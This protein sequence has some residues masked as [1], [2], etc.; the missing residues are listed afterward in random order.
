MKP[1]DDPPKAPDQQI[2]DHLV[3]LHSLDTDAVEIL[4]ATAEKH[5]LNRIAEIFVRPSLLASS[6]DPARWNDGEAR[7]LGN[8]LGA[9]FS[10][11]TVHSGD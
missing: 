10:T 7:R 5:R 9:V 1:I 2:F 11:D 8:Q 3:S 6:P 4:V